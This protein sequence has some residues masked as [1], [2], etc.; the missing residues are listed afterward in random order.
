MSDGSS[1]V[2]CYGDSNTWGAIPATYERYGP[3]ER[4]TGVLAAQL[5]PAYQVIAEGLGGR[6]TVWDD[7]IEGDKNCREY[8]IPCLEMHKPLSLHCLLASPG[9]LVQDRTRWQSLRRGLHCAKT[10]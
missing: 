3:S 8:L 5:G 6:T 7:P 4:W 10:K 9:L 2:L 1:G